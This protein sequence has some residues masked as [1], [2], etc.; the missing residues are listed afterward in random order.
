MFY[1]EDRQRKIKPNSLCTSKPLINGLKANGLRAILVSGTVTAIP[2]LT[3]KD[4]V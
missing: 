2:E 4:C 3:Y 1:L